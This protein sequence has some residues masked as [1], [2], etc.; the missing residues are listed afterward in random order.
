MHDCQYADC[1]RAHVIAVVGRT[2]RRQTLRA[3]LR[4][5]LMNE[6]LINHRR[7]RRCAAMG[8]DPYVSS[9][10]GAHPVAAAASGPSGPREL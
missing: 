7:V 5:L 10:P 6:Y 1:A 8:A 4:W 2:S 3:A 9:L